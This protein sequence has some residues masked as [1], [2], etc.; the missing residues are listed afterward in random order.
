[1]ALHEYN[2]QL[3]QELKT[4]D[5]KYSRTHVDSALEK[6]AADND[7]GKKIIFSDEA[8][9]NQIVTT[10]AVRTLYKFRRIHPQRVSVWR[11]LCTEGIIEPYFL[12][13]MLVIRLR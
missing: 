2:I 5:H 7:L 10:V 4:A 9:N 6:S 8:G 13:L 12:K 3:T 11:V 1:M